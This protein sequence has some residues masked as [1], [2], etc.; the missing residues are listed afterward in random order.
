M[1]GYTR[2]SG[3]WGKNA[4]WTRSSGVWAK[5]KEAYAN[6]AGT[7]RQWWLDGGINDRTFTEFDVYS[8]FSSNVISIAV[9]SDGKVVIGGDFRTFNGVTAIRIARLNSDGT[10]D[11]TFTTNTGTGFNESVQSIAIQSD[12]K[13]V[14]GGEFTGFNSINRTRLARIGGE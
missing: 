12:G 5:A 13:I 4:P 8:G 6:V 10:L 2:A 14:C 3:S 1:P 9:Q 7:W 11:T